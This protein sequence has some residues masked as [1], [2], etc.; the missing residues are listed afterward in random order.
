M[1]LGDVLTLATIALAVVLITPIWGGYIYRVMEGQRTF[2]S[3]VL[4]P[5]ERAIYRVSGIDETVEQSWKGYTLAVLAM[6]V[7]AIALG[8]VV[9]RLQDVLPLNQG[10]I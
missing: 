1:S 9:L 5:V 8:Y 6:A 3:P 10:G 4:R 2:L 7:V